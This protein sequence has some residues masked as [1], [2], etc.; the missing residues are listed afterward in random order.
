MLTVAFYVENTTSIV[1]S[2]IKVLFVAYKEYFMEADY[3]IDH[4]TQNIVDI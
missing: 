3:N 1:P 4:H 2:N